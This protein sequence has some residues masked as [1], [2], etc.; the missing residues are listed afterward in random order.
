MRIIFTCTLLLSTLIITAQDMTRSFG[1][2]I[3][4]NAEQRIAVV[5]FEPRMIISDLHRDM[6]VKNNMN[7]QQ[8]REALSGGFCYAMR[9]TAPSLSET[10]VFGW[11]DPW[12]D[13]LESLY[14][15]MGYKNAP[16]TRREIRE[17]E[18]N[19]GAYIEEGQLRYKYDTLTR[20]MKPVIPQQLLSGLAEETG[21]DFVLI[22]SELDI[23]NLGELTRVTPGKADF[24]VRLHYALY[25]TSGTF[26]DGGLVSQQLETASYNPHDI[27]R[28]EFKAV[29]EALYTALNEHLF[30][31]EET[32]ETTDPRTRND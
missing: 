2:R 20:F 7:S 28:N 1:G 21:V 11:D 24:Y 13:A 14:K 31:V 26:V 29:T 15:E 6:C 9:Q 8:V 3:S 16:V 5:P 19:K 25:D 32:P 17:E 4:S 27:A 23:V 30:P 10:D 22:I 18:K 12:P